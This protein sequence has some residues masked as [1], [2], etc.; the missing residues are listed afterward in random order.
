VQIEGRSR[1]GER[2]L[3][4]TVSTKM[5]H[6]LI[7]LFI[8]S[9]LRTEAYISE[10]IAH[11]NYGYVL[12]ADGRVTVL[13]DMARVNFIIALPHH[14]DVP[15][16]LETFQCDKI[17]NRSLGPRDRAKCQNLEQIIQVFQGLR[18]NISAQLEHRV[19]LI[20]RLVDSA[21][22]V[23]RSRRW[24]PIGEVI[25]TLT[26]LTTQED[27][28][29]MQDTLRR[30]TGQLVHATEMW[31]TGSGTFAQSLSVQNQRI[32]NLKAMI[33]IQGR[34]MRDLFVEI[35]D[36]YNFED[37]IVTVLAKTVIK[38]K[39]LIFRATDLDMMYLSFEKLMSGKLPDYLVSHQVL[40]Q[41]LNRLDRQLR[42]THP[43]YTI[44]Y[45]KLHYYYMHGHFM[46]GR[47]LNRVVVSLAIPLTLRNLA[48]LTLYNVV[49]I[50]IPTP[51]TEGHYSELS[52]NFHSIAFGDNSEYYMLIDESHQVPESRHINLR[53]SSLVLRHR[54]IHTCA[55]ALMAAD[56]TLIEEFCGYDIV[57]GE[58]PPSLYKLAENQVLL[59]NIS[60]FIITC[61]GLSDNTKIM[62]DDLQV[63]FHLECDCAIS[64]G[65]Y[66]ISLAAGFCYKHINITRMLTP[67]YILNL[68]Y[69][70]QFFDAEELRRFRSHTVLHKS[71]NVSLPALATESPEYA[72]TLAKDRKARYKMKE[73]IKSTKQ[74][75]R[76]F[77]KLGDYLY[78]SLLQRSNPH[79]FNIF[80]VFDWVVIVTSI[81]AGIALLWVFILS[82]RL[83][84]LTG[85]IA[86]TPLARAHEDM[87]LNYFRTSTV[88]AAS[89]FSLINEWRRIGQDLRNIIPFDVTILIVAFTIFLA[90]LVYRMYYIRKSR[91]SLQLSVVIGNAMEECQITIKTLT[92]PT[93]YYVFLVDRTSEW[94]CDV[95]TYFFFS[96]FYLKK[97]V[98]VV[99]FNDGG[100]R[101]DIPVKMWI[102]PFRAYKLKK[103][104]ARE[105]YVL[106]VLRDVISNKVKNLL[107]IKPILPRQPDDIELQPMGTDTRRLY[108]RLDTVQT[109]ETKF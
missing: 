23:S 65:E 17:H 37:N 72:V 10:Y 38:L 18:S 71:I 94:I 99:L 33:G 1:T 97:D 59:S 43:N 25:S 78:D 51:G 45:K 63:I 58:L 64:A 21:D 7:W 40:Q 106:V 73:I 79:Q 9:M 91:K 24:N 19:G 30:I 14:L 101:L 77:H 34:T 54:S 104:M 62:A 4:Q 12:K 36:L 22:G 56:L 27:L 39:D 88:S 20:Y 48:P 89:N 68:A 8:L 86:T 5:A 47:K 3:S 103:L 85:M 42:H 109:V 107:I 50:P 67:K 26:G 90:L 83:R 57:V 44:L 100:L 61:H 69:L 92:Y 49:K 60:E 74:Q 98:I 66:Y 32:D 46:V 108:P 13:V 95:V 6:F 35:T 96:Y 80:A 31:R 81:V 87:H 52:L 70:T 55:T 84:A 16:R 41:E 105:H 102:S 11:H 82:I 2:N 93:Q 15:E 75:E 53:H 76:S 29:P 28:K